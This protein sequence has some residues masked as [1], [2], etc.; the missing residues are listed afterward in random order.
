MFRVIPPG[1]ALLYEYYL[2]IFQYIFDHSLLLL[3]C[4][5]FIY[6]LILY[7]KNE[8]FIIVISCV[9][10]NVFTLLTFIF[11]YLPLLTLTIFK[12]D[13]DTVTFLWLLLYFTEHLFAEQLQKDVP[14][15]FSQVLFF[16]MWKVARQWRPAIQWL[17]KC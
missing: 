9:R 5:F 8:S 4:S 12:R 7:L 16:P 13:F 15:I 6:I 1:L 3:H 14:L 10:N 11:T 2:L 17:C